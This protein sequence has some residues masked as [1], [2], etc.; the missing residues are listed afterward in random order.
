MCTRLLLLTFLAVTVVAI[1][2]TKATDSLGQKKRVPATANFPFIQAL[3]QLDKIEQKMKHLRRWNHD[4]GEL[5]GIS[6]RN[7]YR[8]LAL[9]NMFIFH[10]L[11]TKEC[12]IARLLKKTYP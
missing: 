2:E 11:T 10:M 1:S 3:Q 4:M 8:F 6:K 12:W 9:L 7:A 5:N